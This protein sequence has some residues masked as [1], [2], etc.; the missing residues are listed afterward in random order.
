MAKVNTRAFLIFLVILSVGVAG[1]A[2]MQKPTAPQA[3]AVVPT[4]TQEPKVYTGKVNAPNGDKT[5]VMRRTG[6]TYEFFVK[7]KR[8]FSKT[9]PQETTMSLPFNAWDPTEK[10]IF[11]EEKTGNTVNYFVMKETG[12]EVFDVGVVW[13]EKK[14]PYTIR[15]ATGWASGT[16]LIIYTSK[17][18]GSNGPAFWFEVPSTAILQLAG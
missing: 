16:L 14:I 3:A 4:P 12:E 5:L 18:D 8:I 10:W 17:N 6:Q 15:A 9:V 1:A 13:N 11:L 2:V 7:G